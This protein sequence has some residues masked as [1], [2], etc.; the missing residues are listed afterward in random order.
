MWILELKGL[1]TSST[2]L[3]F[4]FSCV[5]L[6]ICRKFFNLRCKNNCHG[7]AFNSTH[8]RSLRIG[9][10]YIRWLCYIVQVPLIHLCSKR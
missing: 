3:P 9:Q 2:N 8:W 4:A 7:T 1:I 10:L 5:L 6:V